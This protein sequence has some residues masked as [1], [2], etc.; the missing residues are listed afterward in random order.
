LAAAAILA[1][2]HFSR[3]FARGDVVAAVAATALTELAWLLVQRWG[4]SSL[5]ELVPAFFAAGF[6]ALA[7]SALTKE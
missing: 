5:Y 4:F 1:V 3:A 7:V 2:G 6:A